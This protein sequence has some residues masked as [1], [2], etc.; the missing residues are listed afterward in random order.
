MATEPTWGSG[1]FREEHRNLAWGSFGL[2]QE[3][4]LK[5]NQILNETYIHAQVCNPLV[6]LRIPDQA[7]HRAALLKEVRA[8]LFS[9]KKPADAMNDTDAAW[10]ELDAKMTPA[11][12]LSTYKMSISL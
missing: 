9:G 3:E 7:S 4:T 8:A 11:Q 10:R 1:I 5:L 2:G 6:R 12:R